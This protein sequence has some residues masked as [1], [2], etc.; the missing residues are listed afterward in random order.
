MHLEFTEEEQSFRAQIRAFLR[1]RL[2]D[3]IRDK[4]QNGRELNR[5]PVT[6]DELTGLRPPV[7][8][9]LAP[10][11]P[12]VPGQDA[13]PYYFVMGSGQQKLM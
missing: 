8:G 6:P 1:E 5:A 7:Q 4:V 12:D 2:P 10:A 9:G 11:A 3:D 13:V